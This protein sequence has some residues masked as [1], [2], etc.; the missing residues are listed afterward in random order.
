MTVALRALR[1]FGL[2]AV[3]AL[4]GQTLPLRAGEGQIVHV[5]ETTTL[6]LDGKGW[7][8]DR[9]ASRQVQLVAVQGSGS[10]FSV[11]GLKPGQ[12]TLVFRSGPKTFSASLDVLR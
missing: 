11:R 3:L 8:L 9:S 5:G 6:H 2:V 1:I 4:A 12:V 7:A 10:R